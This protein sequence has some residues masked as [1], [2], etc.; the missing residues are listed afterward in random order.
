MSALAPREFG[1]KPY[2]NPSG[3][4]GAADRGGAA[5]GGYGPGYEWLYSKGGRGAI[6][7]TSSLRALQDEDIQRSEKYVSVEIASKLASYSDPI[8]L[9]L[10]PSA[11]EA[12]V[13]YVRRKYVVGSTASEVPERAPAPVSMVKEDVREVR[14]Q[15]YGGDI[16]F[17]LNSMLKPGMFKAEMDMKI[18]AQ[19]AALSNKLNDIGYKVLMNEGT[20]LEVALTRSISGGGSATSANRYFRSNVFAA[21]S[22]FDFPLFNLLAAA[23]R[24]SAY[25]IS[26]ATKTVLILPA[27]VPELLKYTKTS[28]MMYNVTGEAVKSKA[29]VQLT[30][31]GGVELPGSGASVFVHIP[32][33]LNSA[34]GGAANP[35]SARSGLERKILYVVWNDKAVPRQVCDL[36]PSSGVGEPHIEL[37]VWADT[38]GKV[39][40]AGGA[41]TGADYIQAGMHA[42]EL[43]MLSAIAAV[44]GSDTG[45]LLMQYPRTTVSTDASTESGRVA[46]RVYMGAVLKRPDNVLVMHDVACSNIERVNVGET[47]DTLDGTIVTKLQ[48]TSKSA[49]EWINGVN[50]AIKNVKRGTGGTFDKKFGKYDDIIFEAGSSVANWDTTGKKWSA[51]NSYLGKLDHPNNVHALMGGQI[52]ADLQATPRT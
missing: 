1:D 25:D 14:L 44:T 9:V 30:V 36:T 13:I 21:L 38:K 28:Q 41:S 46:L 18:E 6:R 39:A 31:D 5:P 35:Y 37:A 47:F 50:D 11:E 40:D 32:P 7:P 2:Q 3:H 49:E 15:R 43:T 4:A 52:F 42:Y 51:N 22:K 34:P 27:G 10:P 20:P 24:C 16:D 17:N 12:A 23:K 26:R 8:K 45:N 48:I 33:A 19:H 29:P